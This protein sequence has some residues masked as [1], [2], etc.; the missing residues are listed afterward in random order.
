M[1]A[2][3]IVAAAALG[4][5][6]SKATAFVAGPVAQT[7][8]PTARTAAVAISN[9]AEQ[10][11]R[12]AAGVSG[13][14]CTGLSLGLVGAAT[15]AVKAK[16]SSTARAAYQPTKE[17]GALQPL[18]YWDPVGM[19]KV[20]S[21]KDGFEWKSEE[22][23]QNYRIAE[24]KHGRVAMAAVFGMLTT[25]AWKFPGF[26]N[27]PD[28]LAALEVEK[29]ASGFGIIVLLASYFEIKY[30]KGDFDVPGPWGVT[31]DL[32]TKEIA[33]GRLAMMAAITLLLTEYGDALK[34]SEQFGS[35]LA[36]SL[37]ST[38]GFSAAWA[39]FALMFLWT[40]PQ[41]F[42]ELE[43]S[44]KNALWSKGL[45]EK[46]APLAP[47]VPVT[48]SESLPESAKELAAVEEVRE[49]KA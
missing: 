14:L 15:T 42:D 6:G 7:S 43:W 5:L 12:P 21:G 39:G 29:G 44:Y 46:P 47:P 30:P 8:T 27:V 13:A 16:K 31:D 1:A 22:T 20:R 35:M 17:L 24:L 23:F 49:A 25:S 32:K 19:M 41:A 3:P 34:P 9:V 4:F 2:S 11:Q 18:G 48:L 26:E 38:F 28:G 10:A 33:N 36:V 45:G 40:Q 37:Q